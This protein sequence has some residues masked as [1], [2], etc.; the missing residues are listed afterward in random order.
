MTDDD[1][2]LLTEYCPSVEFLIGDGYGIYRRLSHKERAI[3]IL[4]ALK[5]KMVESGD[6]EKFMLYAAESFNADKEMK[7]FT[8][9]IINP[10]RC[11]TVAD[12]L[13]GIGGA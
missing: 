5:E 13:R 10:D 6:W 12:W 9:W 2:K 8:D 1:R 7:N 4:Y 3:L 11:E